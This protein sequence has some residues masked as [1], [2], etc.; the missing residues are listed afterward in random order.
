MSESLRIA[1]YTDTFLPAVDGVV[2]S[3][4]N[5][6]RELMRRGHEVHVFAGGNRAT[7]RMV[8][9]YKDI[10]ITRGISFKKYPQY[11]LGIFPTGSAL[12]TAMVKEFDI[13]HAHTPFMVGG[14]ALLM[15]RLGR[16]PLVGTFHTMFMDQSAIREYTVGN[17]RMRK[18]ILKYS[19]NY[20]RFFYGRCD[21]VIAPSESVRS[22]LAGRGIGN[23][24]VVPNSVDLERF[25]PR[26]SGA[27]VRSMLGIRRG[28]RV[29]LYAGRVSREKKLETMIEAA[30]LLRMDDIRFVIVGSG[31]AYDY[32][33]GMV[34]RMGLTHKF[35]FMGFVD[36]REL[37]RYYAAADAFCIPSKFETQGIAPIEAM[38]C[39]K[40][41]VG[42][43]YL[44]LKELISN[45]K[46]GEKF[47]A[48]DP[49]ACARKI[50]KVIYNIE[51]YKTMLDT[52]KRYSVKATT[53]RLLEAYYKLL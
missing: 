17:P 41:V 49:K 24:D 37:P 32:Y 11:N 14:Q 40:P 20:A 23:V 1:F 48:G 46:N 13:I 52:A 15:S 3:I 33:R 25:S 34:D 30:G 6:R 2:I 47:R 51:S 8:M 45:G 5:F 38:A 26:A 42:A 19:W 44:A 28:E 7:K 16:T 4:L 10:H 12:K 9:G 29:L 22:L 39:G 36:N 53:D 18:I 50:R 21:E 35:N 27:K 43:D 31:P